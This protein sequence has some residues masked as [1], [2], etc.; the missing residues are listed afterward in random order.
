MPHKPATAEEHLL[1]VGKLVQNA[2]VTDVIMF[3]AFQLLSGCK[4]A[5]ARAI[6]YAFDSLAGRRGL[7]TRLLK[8]IGDERDRQ[9]TE[10]IIS[11]A[12][13]AHKQRNRVA[14]A[15]TMH[16]LPNLT[17]PVKLFNP[18]S[19]DKPEPVSIEQL[20]QLR[21]ESWNAVRGALAAYEQ[22]CQKHGVQATPTLE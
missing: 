6:Y 16:D 15:L 11:T 2:A 12:E 22:L 3:S 7:L 21:Q 10:E 17:S 9:M 5:I 1:T 18:K 20:A 14:H 19:S 13:K 4:P 8:V